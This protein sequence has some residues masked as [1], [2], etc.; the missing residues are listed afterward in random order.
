MRGPRSR[1]SGPERG[2]DQGIE[3]GERTLWLLITALCVGGAER[4]LVDLANGL[5]PAEYDVTV[6]TIFSEAPLAADLDDHITVRSLTDSGRVENGSV[7]GANNPLAYV[8]APLR[9]CYAAWAERPDVIQSFLIFDNVVARLAGVVCP[10]TIIT[11]VRS[12]PNDRSLLRE[13]LDRLTIGLADVI[14]SNS[15]SGAEYATDL[16]ADPESVTVVRNGRD[17]EHYQSADATAVRAELDVGDDE[18]VVGTVGRLLERKGYFELLTAWCD[19]QTSVP[20]A[21]LVLAGDGQ[22][23]EELEAHA[24]DLGCTD[25]VE[26]LGN[27]GDVPELLAAMDVFAFPSHFEGLPGA[28]I[29]AMA[30]GLPVVA[31][32]VDGTP[33][34][35]DAFRSALFVPVEDP[36]QLAWALT[37]ALQS[38]VLR[39]ELGAAAQGDAEESFTIDAMVHGFET[40]YAD[41][42][43]EDA[44]ASTT[45]K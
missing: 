10:A 1:G 14:V 37:R 4:T 12:V 26:F 44:R 15:A 30:A 45:V 18:L 16:G 13:G 42:L 36:D 34:L 27:R 35:L 24:A 25:S 41:V 7:V 43:D 3:S 5:D 39:R 20:N 28:V 9:F 38:P 2:G 32:P 31:T 17:V 29:E 21:R 19:V 40:V 22:D 33:E 8:T 23:R 6:W 11:G